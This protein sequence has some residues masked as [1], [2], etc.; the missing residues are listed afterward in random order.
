MMTKDD[1]ESDLHSQSTHDCGEV[2]STRCESKGGSR[3]STMVCL[4]AGVSEELLYLHFSL[5]CI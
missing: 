1:A 3:R 2:S 4:P 5:S